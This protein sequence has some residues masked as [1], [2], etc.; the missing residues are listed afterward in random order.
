M[1]A[2]GVWTDRPDYRV[3]IA[4]LP[5]SAFAAESVEGAVAVVA[6][7]DAALAALAGGAAGLVVTSVD[8]LS[9]EDIELVA[10]VARGIPVVVD[11]L[12]LRTDV[13]GEAS[14]PATTARLLTA[15]AA[16]PAKDFAALARDAVGWLRVLAGDR[17]SLVSHSTSPS[18][19][20]AL[21]ESSGGERMP[22]ALTLTPN[23]G[24]DPTLRVS[25]VGEI[26]IEV[27]VDDATRGAVITSTSVDGALIAPARLEW[28]ARLAV[29]RAIAAL[30]A[31]RPPEDLDELRHDAVL[32]RELLLAH[33][34]VA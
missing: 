7:A 31:D 19:V 5:L 23:R 3:A 11:R 33:R 14:P 16:G 24:A 2:T 15:E 27:D 34:S 26:R 18:G 8:E 4:E 32:V 21:L 22:A 13:I 9:A 12:R 17:L 29:R 10:D 20:L 6:G 28:P 1:N 30:S 25:S